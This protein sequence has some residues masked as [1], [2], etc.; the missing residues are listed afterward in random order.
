M[1]KHRTKEFKETLFKHNKLILEI[2]YHLGNG[3]ML[4]DQLK[5]IIRLI[6]PLRANIN[7][8][9]AEL[10]EEGFL[11]E[12]QVLL[13]NKYAL[14]LTKYPIAKIR[15][16]ESRNATSIRPSTEKILN[17][18]YRTELLIK[19]IPQIKIKP[20][21]IELI[22]RALNLSCNTLLINKNNSLEVYKSLN[23]CNYIKEFNL[24]EKF[25]N[26]M[27]ISKF[28]FET[29]F[30]K[31]KKT[32]NDLIEAKEKEQINKEL[33]KSNVFF[34]F[35]NMLNRNFHIQ[36]IKK[37]ELELTI[38]LN[39]LD[40]TEADSY[41]I[42]YSLGCIYNMFTKYFNGIGTGVNS[43]Y[44]FKLNLICYV[45]TSDKKRAEELKL[46]SERK[47]PD[48]NGGFKE[49]ANGK[50]ALSRAGVSNIDIDNDR[51]KVNYRYLDFWSKYNIN[52]R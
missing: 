52:I 20:L 40:V 15:G 2:L 48:L 31:D 32:N 12:K 50:N 13:S 38:A 7:K 44:S 30:K 17:S 4:Q 8:D 27:K 49:Y 34:N 35:S 51:I 39:Y 14:Y 3:I 42:Y 37:N 22:I 46:N 23:Y 11:K 29:R 21:T 43:T 28:N 24:N 18:L 41:K 47:V 16:I 45:N 6:E 25:E 33:Y 1:S 36:G 9:I 26:D 5:A 19:L 10:V